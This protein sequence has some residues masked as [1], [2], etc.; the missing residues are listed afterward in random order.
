[1]TLAFSSSSPIV[2]VA[3]FD[4]DGAL[5]SSRETEGR[6]KASGALLDLLDEIL[7]EANVTLS[8]VKLFASDLGPGS[9]TGVKIAVTVCKTLAYVQKRPVCGATAFDLIDPTSTVVVPFKKREYFL[10]DVGSEP[11]N[12]TE[13]PDGVTGYGQLFEDPVYPSAARFAGLLES[14]QQMEPVE[15]IPYYVAEPSISRPKN[16]KLVGRSDD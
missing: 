12:V 2:S 15:L 4:S 6:R 8:D 11:V 7:E 13:I 9:F 16:P 1:M 3:L 14:C 5:V 10:R